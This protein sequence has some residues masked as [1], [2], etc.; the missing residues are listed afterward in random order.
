MKLELAKTGKHNEITLTPDDLKEIHDNFKGDIPVTIGHEID[1]A[2]PAYGWVKSVELSEDGETL[3]G[4]IELNEELAKAIA[5]GKYK[6]WSIGAGVTDKGMYLHHVAFLGAVPPMI[7][8]LKLIEMGDSSDIITFSLNG[9]SKFQLS[10][11]EMSE[12]STLKAQKRE[13]TLKKLSDAS[14]GKLPFGK[15]EKLMEFADSQLRSS[16][17]D[18][19]NL[20]TE[21]FSSVKSPVSSGVSEIFRSKKAESVQSVF[22]KI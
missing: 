12:Y 13:A 20:L 9:D 15:R 6:N 19:V 1:D 18:T 2:M 10:D 7:K 17:E 16:N 21:I 14:S 22:S 8:D 3:I 4:E 11:K 5:D